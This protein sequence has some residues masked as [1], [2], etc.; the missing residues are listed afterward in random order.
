[1]NAMAR[2]YL[3]YLTSLT[4]RFT[5]LTNNDTLLSATALYHL[6]NV[7]I[8]CSTRK[9]NCDYGTHKNRQI[10]GHHPNIQ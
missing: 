3:Y 1:M 6:S 5:N 8:H 7:P 9:H 10:L 2:T 4:T